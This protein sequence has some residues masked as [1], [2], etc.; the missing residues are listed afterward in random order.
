VGTLQNVGGKA[1]FNDAIGAHGV[2]RFYRV[3]E[4]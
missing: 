3:V 1:Q 4:D 2:C